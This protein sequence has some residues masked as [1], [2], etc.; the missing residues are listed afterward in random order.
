MVVKNQLWN[1]A[2]VKKEAISLTEAG[3]IVTIIAQAEDGCPF[4]ETWKNIRI[5]RPQKDSTHR[6]ALR[7]KVIGSSA[8]DD[9]SLKSRIIRFLRRNRF[10]RFLTDLKRNVPWEY[11]LYRAA[12][13][14]GADIFHAN[15]LDTLLICERAAG[16]LGA[17]LVYDSHELWLESSR[18]FIATSALNKLRYR[19][20]ER[21]LIPK[22]DAVIAVTPSRG[23]V[24]KNMYPSISRLVIIENSTAPIMNLPESSYLRNR[25]GIPTDVPVILYQGVICPERGLDKLLEA[26]SILRDE[27]IAIVIIGHDVWQGTLHRMHSEMNLKNSVFLLPPVPSEILPEITVS[28]DAGLILFENTCLNHYYSL[29]NKLYEYMMAGLPVIAADF[30]EMA[31]IINKHSCGILVDSANAEAI[32][33]GIRTLTRSPDEMRQMGIQGRNASLEKYNWPVEEKKLVDLY[34][35]LSV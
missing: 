30:P 32:A 34:M 3:F 1:D 19:I 26:A 5:L 35:S 24:M 2:R 18:Y 17:K 28:A 10:R 29:P 4:E 20:T 22:T 27:D 11:R 16:K 15:D 33:N 6:N 21:K 14:T 31:R 9:N 8:E 23:E 12:L 7:E 13:S 25:L